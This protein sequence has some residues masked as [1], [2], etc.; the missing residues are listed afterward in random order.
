MQLRSRVQTDSAGQ[1][2]AAAQVMRAWMS[3]S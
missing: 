2:N 3:E 1:P